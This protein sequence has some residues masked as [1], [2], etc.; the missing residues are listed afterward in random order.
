MSSTGLR[1]VRRLR[2]EQIIEQV[3]DWVVVLEGSVLTPDLR[4]LAA[5]H[6]T[7]GHQASSMSAADS[8][9]RPRERPVAAP[10]Q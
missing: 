6:I 5:T 4:V 7:G 8:T 10:R 1:A 2:R 3:Q 9:F